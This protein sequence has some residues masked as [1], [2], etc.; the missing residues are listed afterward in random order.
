ML[1]QKTKKSPGIDV[2]A[3]TALGRWEWITLAIW[4]ARFLY[5]YFVRSLRK[6]IM[7]YI[8]LKLELPPPPNTSQYTFSW[9][10][11]TPSERT[12]F[13]DDPQ[14]DHFLIFKQK[15]IFFVPYMF[16]FSGVEF[17]WYGKWWN[18]SSTV[19]TF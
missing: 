19:R 13:M 4:K 12:C 9:T 16:Y 5:F 1:I 8:G 14:Q 6:E 7:A 2:V 11:L 18:T 10:T 17:S 15:C 3:L